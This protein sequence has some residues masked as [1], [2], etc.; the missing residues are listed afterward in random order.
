MLTINFLNLDAK[1][2]AELDFSTFQ[3]IFDLMLRNRHK[4][5]DDEYFSSEIPYIQRV[6]EIILRHSPF[7]WL[8]MDTKTGEFLGFCYLYDIVR[9]KGR[10]FAA[11]ATICFKKEAWGIKAHIAAKRLLHHLFNDL[12][13]FKI[14]A[15]CYSDNL[16]MPNFL[17]KLGFE[18][19]ATLK[20]ETIV[21]KKPKNI[22]IWSVFN[23][24]LYQREECSC[25]DFRPKGEG[26][27][28]PGDPKC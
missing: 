28:A 2:L 8:F 12:H 11:C 20:Y 16:Y 3:Q 27:S 7:F 17:K 6:Y 26:S 10:M 25:L 13:L 18:H 19:E 22:E 23:L 14:K 9:F 24:E 15:E 4:L 1:G 5:F 21:Q